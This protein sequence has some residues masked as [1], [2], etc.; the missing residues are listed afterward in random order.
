MWPHIRNIKKYAYCFL[1]LLF[2]TY[3]I[4]F[5]Y[6]IFT[7]TRFVNLTSFLCCFLI[8]A[9][10]FASA[11]SN[12]RGSLWRCDFDFFTCIKTGFD[13]FTCINVTPTQTKSPT[14]LLFA[15]HAATKSACSTA[16][17]I[18]VFFSSSD[19]DDALSLFS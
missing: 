14:S 9:A 6:I 1:F 7:C 16:R 10:S 4:I 19:D 3:Y 18:L 11:L 17:L 12:I 5:I 8:F 2:C 15:Y 13:F